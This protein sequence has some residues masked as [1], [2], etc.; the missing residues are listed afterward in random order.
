MLCF[1]LCTTALLVLD[2]INKHLFNCTSSW[3]GKKHFVGSAATAEND[4]FERSVFLRKLV[5]GGASMGR[6]PRREVVDPS[7]VQ[8]FHILNRT[9]RRC[10]LF[11][12]DELTGKNYDHRKEWIEELLRRFAGLFGI[13]LLSYAILSNHYHLMLRSRPDVVETWDDTEVARRWLM[14]CPKRKKKDGT[15]CEPNEKELDSIRNSKETLKLIR[16]RLS[17]VSWWTRLL[18]QRIARRCNDEDKATGR[19]FEDRFKAIPLLDE[20]SIAACAL[21]IDLNL[22]RA[23]IAETVELSDHTSGQLRAKA[24]KARAE[25]ALVAACDSASS[26][27]STVNPESTCDAFLSPICVSAVSSDPGPMPSRS[28][29]RCSD[30]GFLEMCEADYIQLLDWTARYAAPGKR[31]TTSKDLPPIL[32]RLGFSPK[33]WLGMVNDFGKLFPMIA[34][35]PQRLVEARSLKSGRRY[36]IPKSVEELFGQSP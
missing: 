31:G 27:E 6:K 16:S 30:K 13:D 17:D 7:I 33:I 11:G 4:S 21:Y 3:S 1:I 18:D 35:L 20:E 5:A 19:F 2:A 10:F 34:G 26:Q 14:I 15:P 12:P 22:I 9:V 28:G 29:L 25:Q 36:R 23:A 32:E 24:L 8:V